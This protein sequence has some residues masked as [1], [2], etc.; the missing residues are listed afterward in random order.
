MQRILCEHIHIRC[1]LHFSVWTPRLWVCRELQYWQ[2]WA[3]ITWT[4]S[5]PGLIQALSLQGVLN[6]VNNSLLELARALRPKWASE[7]RMGPVM[8]T[9]FWASDNIIWIR[10]IQHKENVPPLANSWTDYS[11]SMARTSKKRYQR[12]RIAFQS[13][14]QQESGLSASVSLGAGQ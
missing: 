5:W 3:G 9:S 2:F 8:S 12:Y 7:G 11:S 13:E 10:K 6:K 1:A 14:T 4:P